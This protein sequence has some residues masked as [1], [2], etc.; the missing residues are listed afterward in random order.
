MTDI[1]ILARGWQALKLLDIHSDAA[2][3]SPADPESRCDP[4]RAFAAALIHGVQPENALDLR[5]P[6]AQQWHREVQEAD[7]IASRYI[8]I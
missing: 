1:E 6:E 3:A 7:R 2:T 5:C 4:C 8:P